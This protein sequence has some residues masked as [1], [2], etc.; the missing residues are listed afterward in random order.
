MSRPQR[1]TVFILCLGLTTTPG[2]AANE[3][4]SVEKALGV[5]GSM[6]PDGV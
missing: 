4:Q 1:A 2:L 3:W 6:Q 5:S